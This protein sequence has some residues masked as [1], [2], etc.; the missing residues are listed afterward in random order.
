FKRIDYDSSVSASI[1]QRMMT[2]R[3]KIAEMHRSEGAGQAAEIL[4]ERE[5][6][7][8]EIESE[9]Y[10]KVQEVEGAADAK[11]TEIYAKAYNATPEAVQLFEFLKTM[12][13]YKKLITTDTQ[14]IFTTDSDLFRFL[15]SADPA[16][17][18]PPPAPFAA[19][20][21]NPTLND[22]LSKLPSLLEVK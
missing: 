21:L 18:A 12:D 1:H 19:P 2:E 9:A 15:K 14:M 7:L 4:G 3:Q 8:A 6:D 10:R 16:A 13:A 11:A 20:M 22:P 17:K 5:R